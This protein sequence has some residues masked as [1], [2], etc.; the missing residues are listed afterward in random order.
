MGF[1]VLAI[2]GLL[3]VHLVTEPGSSS[4]QVASGSTIGIAG[5]PRGGHN[6]LQTT[7]TATAST[8]TTTTGPPASEALLFPS[9]VTSYAATRSGIV[10]AA[11]YDLNSGKLYVLNPGTAED[12]ASIV[13]IDVMAALFSQLPGDPAAYPASTRSLL[14]AMVEQSD[15]DSATALWNQVGGAA[16]LASFNAKIG[17]SATTPSKCVTCAGFPWPGWGLTT[18]TAMDQVELL[19]Q[20]VDPNSA[21]STA[22]RDYGLNLM[23]NIAPDEAWGVT[24]G[25]PTG[26]TVALKN[27]WLPLTGETNWQVNSIGWVDGDN[28]DYILAILSDSNATEQYGI[29]TTEQIA[30]DVWQLLG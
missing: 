20:F 17:L 12:E 11:L 4:G 23:Q 16:G 29:D 13:K 9:S 10:T 14:E 8:T 7:T 6:S 27:G 19:R 2:V 18:T 5:S 25:V 28:R 24:A 30:S 26:V 1:L 21:L 3:I 22:Q 15:N